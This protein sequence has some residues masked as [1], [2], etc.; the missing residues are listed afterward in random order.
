MVVQ[1]MAEVA[2]VIQAMEA[3]VAVEI[4]LVMVAAQEADAVQ[5]VVTW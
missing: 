5:L 4:A 3:A 2:E 1:A